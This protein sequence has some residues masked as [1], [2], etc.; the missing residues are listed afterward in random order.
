MIFLSVMMLVSS[1]CTKTESGLLG[2]RESLEKYA[3][4]FTLADIRRII[5]YPRTIEREVVKT[6]KAVHINFYIQT[7]KYK[8]RAG[9]EIFILHIEYLM[10]SASDLRNDMKTSEPVKGIGDYAWYESFKRG[11]SE[12]IYYIADKNILVGLEG[13]NRGSAYPSSTLIDREGFI[14]LAKLIEN[15]L[16]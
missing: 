11:Q 13:H 9:D 6:P 7:K 16:K 3:D 14:L 12:L 15:R 1:G 8:K 4:V 5:S 2:K 10:S